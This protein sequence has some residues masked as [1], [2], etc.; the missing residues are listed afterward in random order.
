M[1]DFERQPTTLS[2]HDHNIVRESRQNQAPHPE[3]MLNFNIEEGAEKTYG[4]GFISLGIISLGLY[5][6][7]T[8]F[9]Y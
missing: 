1:A 9:L 6:S 3:N 2:N 8:V 7:S 5:A 4:L